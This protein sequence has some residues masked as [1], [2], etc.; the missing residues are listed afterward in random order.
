MTEQTK[1]DCILFGMQFFI[2]R[3]KEMPITDFLVRNAELYPNEVCLVE[4]NPA[5][6]K[7]RTWREYE[8]I[9]I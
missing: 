6:Q 9:E 5:E 1:G 2:D 4:I 8:L 3:R 7:S